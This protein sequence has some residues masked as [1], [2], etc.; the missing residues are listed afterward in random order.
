M[1]YVLVLSHPEVNRLQLFAA[2]FVVL[3]STLG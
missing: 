1:S 3:R 2:V